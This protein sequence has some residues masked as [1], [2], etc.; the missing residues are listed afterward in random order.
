VCYVKY[1]SDTVGVRKFRHKRT[2]AVLAPAGS[3]TPLE[4]ETNR[5]DRL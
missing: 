3:G 4:R 1:L 5:A 2:V